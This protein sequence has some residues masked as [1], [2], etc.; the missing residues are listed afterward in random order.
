MP[1]DEAAK[2]K[3]AMGIV[4]GRYADETQCS[5]DLSKRQSTSEQAIYTGPNE[6][7]ALA[8]R[9]AVF[10]RNG[11]FTFTYPERKRD[12]EGCDWFSQFPQGFSC[13]LAVTP[14]NHCR[15]D[16]FVP[17]PCSEVILKVATPRFCHL[18]DFANDCFNYPNWS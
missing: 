6:E 16:Q 3:F 15:Y 11:T 1:E 2:I 17:R 8:D 13:G 7:K 12:R 18:G 5:H 4:Y 14:T 10:Y 9:Y